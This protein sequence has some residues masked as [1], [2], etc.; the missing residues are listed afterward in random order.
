MSKGPDTY[1]FDYLHKETCYCVSTEQLNDEVQKLIIKIQ[2]SV[3]M[4]HGNDDRGVVF[5]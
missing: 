1:M 2:K 3:H 4:Q 5:I